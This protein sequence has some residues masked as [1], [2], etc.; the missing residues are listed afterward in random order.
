MFSYGLEI[1]FVDADRR[2][3]LLPEGCSFNTKEVT[4]VNSNGIAVDSTKNSKNWLGGE[5]NT[6]PTEDIA[7]Q[8]NVAYKCLKL[9]KQHNATV[10]Y[11]CNLHAHVGLPPEL[12]TLDTLKKVQKYAF[13]NYEDTLLLT[14]GRGQYNKKPEYPVSF[15]SHYKERMVPEYKHNFL[16]Q[17]KDLK[18]FQMSFFKSK[19][20]KHSPMTF[21]R[22][23]VNTHS[24]FKTKTIEFRIFWATLDLEEI[25]ACLEF[26]DFF[27]FNA[28]M[29]DKPKPVKSYYKYFEGRFPKELPFSLT[30]EKSFQATKVPKP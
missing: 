1:E 23:G 10:N 11:R 6:S 5:I 21:M 17:A 26:S 4:L 12:Q 2:N 29:A 16:L 19:E 28:I 7:E 30:L 25:K 24:F 14:M 8:L 9:L 18:D 22:Q 13:D 20:G 15:W 3:I 27:V